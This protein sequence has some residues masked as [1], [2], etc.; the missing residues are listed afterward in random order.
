M[1][2]W[3]LSLLTFVFICSAYAQEDDKIWQA[4]PL[5]RPQNET[6][7]VTVVDVA[8]EFPGGIPA[9]AKFLSTNLR[10]PKSA[11]ELQI[12]GKAI[13]K[14][15]VDTEGNVSDITIVKS[16]F[17]QK[18]INE[19]KSKKKKLVYDDIPTKCEECNADVIRVLK[20]TPKWKPA[21]KDGK[22]VKSYFVLPVKFDLN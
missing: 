18:V 14:F 3:I 21:I 22:S 20:L 9:L 15:I 4:Q 12:S 13:A 19:K 2:N 16:S 5:P 11:M 7:V 6:E 1:K 8:A 10:Y 17:W